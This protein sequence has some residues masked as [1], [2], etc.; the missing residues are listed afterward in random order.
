MRLLKWFR[1][2]PDLS[3]PIDHRVGAIEVQVPQAA[4]EPELAPLKMDDDA[5]IELPPLGDVEADTEATEEA[6]ES[7]S[8]FAAIQ[9]D[10]DEVVLPPL[11]D[12]AAEDETD[13]PE[14]AVEAAQEE[15][16]EEAPAKKKKKGWGFFG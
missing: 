10:D 13:A 7:S 9:D 8:S 15:A 5:E 3:T 6:E 14:E 1:K 2:V 16:P 4:D 12:E 11:E